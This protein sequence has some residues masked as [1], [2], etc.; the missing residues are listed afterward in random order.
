MQS[1]ASR[2][3]DTPIDSTCV[4]APGP[5]QHES[6]PAPALTTSSRAIRLLAIAAALVALILAGLAISAWLSADEPELP[7]EYEGFD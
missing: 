3:L 6:E 2:P 7:F 1:L 5:D 4:S